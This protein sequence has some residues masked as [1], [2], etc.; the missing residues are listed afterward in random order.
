M[1]AKKAMD[2][3]V[4]LLPG[5]LGSVLQLDGKDVWA[6]SPRG[7]FQGVTSFGGGVKRLR[8]Q[9]IQ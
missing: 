3:V 7:I 6:P 2:D 4:V 5:I 9:G 1:K 8:I